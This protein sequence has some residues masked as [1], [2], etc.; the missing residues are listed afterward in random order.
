MKEFIDATIFMGMHSSD[1]KIRIACKNFF[2]ERTKKTVF[3]SLENVGKCDDVIWKFDRE[4]QDAYF[5]FMDRIHTIMDIQR[6]PY[7][8]QTL[9]KRKRNDKLSIFQQLSL[10]QSEKGKLFTLDEVLLNL[11]LDFLTSPQIN[12]EEKNF[13]GELETSYQE[14]LILRVADIEHLNQ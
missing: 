10:S 12:N 13:F 1:E 3:M 6:I 4:A 11:K 14:S 2:V 5:P 7:D 9:E 8:E